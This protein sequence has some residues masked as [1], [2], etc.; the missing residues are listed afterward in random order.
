MKRL[1]NGALSVYERVER[2]QEK[3]PDKISGADFILNV[4]SCLN[5]PNCAYS[6]LEP[7]VRVIL[8]ADDE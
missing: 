7:R 8:S 3:D 1:V 6:P 2:M 5:I 4:K